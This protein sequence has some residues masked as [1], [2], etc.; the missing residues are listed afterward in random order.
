MLKVLVWFRND[1]RIHD[2]EVLLK[3]SNGARFYPSIF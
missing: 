1:L 2:N 3:A